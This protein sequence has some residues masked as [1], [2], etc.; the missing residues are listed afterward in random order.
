M[1]HGLTKLGVALVE[2]IND[3]RFS[4][5][6]VKGLDTKRVT[7][8]SSRI[9]AGITV[10][11]VAVGVWNDLGT[12]ARW[13]TEALNHDERF[14]TESIDRCWELARLNLEAVL[15]GHGALLSNRLHDALLGIHAEI[16]KAEAA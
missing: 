16:A 11:D 6:V 15:V 2:R 14:A 10:S 12:A 8:W 7:P 4:D 9:G 5:R 3:V 1:E 13:V